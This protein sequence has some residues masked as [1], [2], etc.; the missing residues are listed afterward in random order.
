MANHFDLEEQEQIDAIKHLWKQ[1]GNLVT[2]L[3][4]AALCAYA[5]WNG[6][7]YWQ[8]RQAAQAAAVYDQLERAV[9]SGD[10]ARLERALADLQNSYGR[11]TDAARGALLAAKVLNDKNQ[12]AQAKAALTWAADKASDDGLQAIARLRLASLQIGEKAY[13]AA[14]QTLAASFPPPYVALAADRRGD[15][16]LLQGK[17]SE[18]AAEFGKA[19]QGLNADTASDYRRLVGFK[20]NALGIDPDAA[21]AKTPS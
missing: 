12:P 7:Q 1:W 13:D 6:W 11:T 18:A 3:L 10:N 5:A 21:T 9:Q 2:W 4:I 20:L 17:R 16:L 15:A 8:R 19:Y 14:L